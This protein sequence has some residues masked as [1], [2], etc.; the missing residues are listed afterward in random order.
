MFYVG[1]KYSTE[2]VKIFHGGVK[3]AREGIKCSTEV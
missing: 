2:D 3:Y 1:A